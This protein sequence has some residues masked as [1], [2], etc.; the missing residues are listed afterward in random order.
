MTVPARLCAWPI[1]TYRL[2]VSPLLPARCRFAPTCSTYALQAL[3]QH[4]A[5]RG[6]WLA[7][8]RLGRCQPFN[9]GGHDPVPPR[10]TRVRRRASAAS[11]AGRDDA[12]GGP[13]PPSPRSL[14]PHR[15]DVPRA[16]RPTAADL[17]A[18]S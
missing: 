12:V 17:G 5:A 15:T 14:A 7:L 4:G 8:R 2:L 16:P 9:P 18:L 10:A 6:S 13:A 3:E 11:R 1:R